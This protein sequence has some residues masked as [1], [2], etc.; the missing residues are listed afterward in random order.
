MCIYLCLEP[1][2]NSGIG[3][4]SWSCLYPQDPGWDLRA[5]NKG[6][7]RKF[8]ENRVGSGKGYVDWGD[9]QSAHENE[10]MGEESLLTVPDLL[11]TPPRDQ[12][13]WAWSTSVAWGCRVQ[14][15]ST[16]PQCL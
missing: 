7:T 4:I 6:L 5:H 14:L 10:G 16:G 11:S 12:P 3:S 15:H 8:T 9:S 2:I 13:S 1:E